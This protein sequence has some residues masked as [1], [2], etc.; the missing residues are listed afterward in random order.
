[1]TVPAGDGA[2]ATG[3]AAAAAAP[4]ARPSGHT[5]AGSTAS[6]P[7][8]FD[9][10]KSRTSD[11]SAIPSL[12]ADDHAPVPMMADTGSPPAPVRSRRLDGML[13]VAA[14]LAI[15][16]AVAASSALSLPWV[17][18]RASVVGQRSN[19]RLV[20][21]VTFRASDSLAGPLTIG[22]AV[23]IALVGLLWFWYGMDR[24]THLPVVAHPG[25]AL[26]AG[27]VA[28]ATLVASKLG[29]SL[30]HDAFLGNAR[31]AGLTKEAMRTVLEGPPGPQLEFEPLGGMVRL[32]AAA[33]LAML[34]GLAAWW[35]QRRGGSRRR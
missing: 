21:V 11:P 12:R 1:M 26:L 31:D 28:L 4:L 19:A 13:I 6:L 34:A 9:H 33:V 14:V 35:S 24:G 30:W 10:A 20:A 17:M 16:S 32:T 23:L 7:S 29:P 8:V 3:D 5:P 25:L 22:V 2:G 27:G 18:G 15:A